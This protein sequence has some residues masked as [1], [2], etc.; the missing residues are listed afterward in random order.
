MEELTVATDCKRNAKPAAE[1]PYPPDVGD[2]DEAK[3]ERED[4]GGSER[5]HVLPQ[6]VAVLIRF[7]ASHF[8]LVELVFRGAIINE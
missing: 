2:R 5:G 1:F 6:V 3:D 7:E 4:G 8:E